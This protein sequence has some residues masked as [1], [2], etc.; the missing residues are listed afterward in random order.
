MADN[1]NQKPRKEW[2]DPEGSILRFKENRRQR[3]G[4]LKEVE[5]IYARCRYTD[6]EGNRREKKRRADSLS[7]AVIKTRNRR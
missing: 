3:N 4:K 6:I 7:D 5:V 1:S 2:R